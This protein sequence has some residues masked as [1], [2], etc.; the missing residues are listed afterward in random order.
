MDLGGSNMHE[1]SR[2]MMAVAR[3]SYQESGS[4]AWG[5]FK[6]DEKL[7]ANL[8]GVSLTLTYRFHIGSEPKFSGNALSLTG[9]NW[10]VRLG[11]GSYTNDITPELAK[12]LGMEQHIVPL[13]SGNAWRYLIPLHFDG[14][15]GFRHDMTLL[16]LF[17]SEWD[18]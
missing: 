16:R 18:Q 5:R 2:V 11:A 9:R 8:F 12:E 6:L 10:F 17:S 3:Q 1:L 7:E 14:R 13:P 15:E 4:R